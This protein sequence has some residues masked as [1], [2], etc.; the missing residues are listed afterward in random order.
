VVDDLLGL[1]ANVSVTASASLPG[2]VGCRPATALDGDPGT[3]WQTPLGAVRDQWLEV[4]VPAPVEIDGLSLQVLDDDR[5]S[6]PARV[7]IEAGTEVR[8][9]D[10]QRAASSNGV[11]TGRVAFP[12]LRGDR[13]RV[14]VTEIDAAQAP[15][16]YTD[17]PQT[18]PVGIAELGLGEVTVSPLPTEFATRCRDDLVTVDGRAL[19]V[20]VRG[21]T[22]DALARRALAVEACG[23]DAGAALGAGEHVLSTTAGRLTGLDLDRV[24][25]ASAAGGEQGLPV[26][27]GR[28]G[29]FGGGAGRALPT[30]RVTEEGRTRLRLAV[31]GATEPF[32]LVL[33]Q[34][35][36]PGWSATL[37]GRGDL[38]APRLVDGYANGWYVDPGRRDAFVVTLEWEPQR[39]VWVALAASVVALLACIAIVIAT[40]RRARM[41][42]AADDGRVEL[43]SPLEPLGG[44]PVRGA[45]FFGPLLAGSIAAIVIEPWAGAAVAASVV[46]A[47]V[48]PRARALLTV[49]PPLLVLAAGIYIV[50]NQI[51]YDL[52]PVFEWPTFFPRARPLAWLA[53]ALAA[54]DALVEQLRRGPHLPPMPIRSRSREAG[55]AE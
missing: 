21:T 3:A 8:E 44:S 24:V 13:F 10:V 2:C 39:R 47:L 38:G 27:Q 5:H 32:W 25:L 51:R 16:F 41:M 20:R 7:R 53:V 36:S 37:S 1:E 15:N 50:R 45:V 33:G 40:R 29:E 28:V 4:R 49:L 54:A 31:E 46:L 52:P 55:E 30:V 17:F 9:A 42:P 22:A 35:H 23:A 43:H 48:V 6:L 12:A 19:R 14:T 34:S 18:L 26:A 11:A